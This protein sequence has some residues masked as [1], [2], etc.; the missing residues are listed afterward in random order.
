MPADWKAGTGPAP[1]YDRDMAYD[2][3]P[4]DHA[5]PPPGARPRPRPSSPAR[6][7]GVG[8][9]S[10]VVG[11][12][13]AV[14]WMGRSQPAPVVPAPTAATDVADGSNRPK[15][16]S[17]NLPSLDGSDQLLR[18]L[19]SV[20]SRH[21]QLARLLATDGLVRGATLAVVQVGEGRTPASPLAV[22]RP[23]SRVT[24][25]G[26][27]SGAVDPTSYARWDASTTALTSIDPAELAQL[28]VN[29]KPLFDEAY[30][31]Q[32][33]PDANFDEAMVRAIAILDGTPDLATDP[34]LLQR[35]DYYIH[36]DPTLRELRP[37]Q[38]Q[39]LLFGQANRQKVSAWLHQ[40]ARA[41]D[42]P[43]G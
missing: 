42:L 20:L 8:V 21:P 28:Y 9:L 40:L 19:V 17:M 14:W 37:V 12:L 10:L 35:P 5:P 13:L 18:E 33:F 39:F 36:E 43:L 31:E 16:Q 38:K 7:I 24:I 27:A 2:D 26:T 41:L 6:M 22:L 32:G 4:L 1:S 25:V 3:L 15:R 23:A 34:V 30:R 29:V 11:A